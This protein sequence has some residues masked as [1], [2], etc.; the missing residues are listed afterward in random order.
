MVNMNIWKVI[1]TEFI[2]YQVIIITFKYSILVSL[3]L[4]NFEIAIGLI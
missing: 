1:Y 3:K 2:K 4:L